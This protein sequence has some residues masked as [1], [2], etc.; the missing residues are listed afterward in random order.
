MK[1][2][3]DYHVD[4]D[5]KYSIG[6][7]AYSQTV[8]DI[9]AEIWSEPIWHYTVGFDNGGYVAIGNHRLGDFAAHYFP[10]IWSEAESGGFWG[11]AETEAEA[12]IIVEIFNDPELV[13]EM[14]RAMSRNGYRIT[15]EGT[16]Y[17]LNEGV[18]FDA[19]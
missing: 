10:N 17:D 15:L 16:A 13:V 11:I 12:K 9:D 1:P 8:I 2:Q 6:G 5:G 14:F 3:F 18:Y 7:S 4:E 19:T